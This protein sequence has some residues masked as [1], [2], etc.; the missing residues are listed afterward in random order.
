MNCSKENMYFFIETLRR[1]EYKAADIHRVLTQA[2]PDDS[3]TE[4]HVRKLCQQFREE[5]R[6]TFE[7]QEG[8]GRPKSERRSDNVETI[9]DLIENDRSMSV[10]TI[11]RILNLQKDMVHR[12]FTDE[13]DMKWVHTKWV[14][15]T[16]SEGNKAVRV[17]R[18]NDL[19]QSLSNRLAQKN[20]VTIDEK[21]FYCRNLKHRNTIGCWVGQSGDEP[22]LQ[23]ARRSNFEKK[24][25][26]IMAVTQR[27]SHFFRILPVNVSVNS[28]LYV[29]FLGDLLQFI[30]LFQPPILPEN[31]RLV[32][33]NAKPHADKATTAYMQSRNIRLLRQPLY[34]PDVNLCDAY[35]F[36]RL[37]A[38]TIEFHDK[39]DLENFLNNEL[40]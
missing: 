31:L 39:S 37:E 29:S 7:R 24:F 33:D 40:P 36:P 30:G 10:V 19:I 15:H 13:L 28:E 21:M 20:L 27:G 3:F 1:V 8:S 16:L 23:T 12:I 4:A 38:L 22:V 5:T 26:V 25:H 6:T 14:P 34:S 17:E 18:C 32:H 35:V 2:W 9:R 11:S